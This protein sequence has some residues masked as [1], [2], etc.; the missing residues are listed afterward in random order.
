MNILRRFNLLMKGRIHAALDR[1]E[2]PERSLNQLVH[3]M[4]EELDAAKRAVAR[5]MA[6][7]DRLR[8]QVAF[9][10][11]DA[12]EWQRAHIGDLTDAATRLRWR[13][14]QSC[15]KDGTTHVSTNSNLAGGAHRRSL[16]SHRRD[17][18]RCLSG[19]PA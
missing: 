5:A 1:I 11:Q 16:G 13:S 15:A 14:H 12:G 10:T 6:N 9:H 3:D 18:D 19:A 2:D 7:E 8:A 4:E 17:R